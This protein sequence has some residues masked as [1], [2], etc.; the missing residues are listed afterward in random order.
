PCQ[1]CQWARL[2]WRWAPFAIRTRSSPSIGRERVGPTLK[3]RKAQRASSSRLAFLPHRQSDVAILRAVVV[4]CLTKPYQAQ[5]L[6]R[7]GLAFAFC[8]E[9]SHGRHLVFTQLRQVMPFP[10]RARVVSGVLATF[11]AASAS[12]QAAP[13]N[14]TPPR[15]RFDSTGVADTSMFAPLNLPPGNEF[16]SG[17]G[18]PGPRYWQQRADYD[19]KATLDTAAKA[20]RGELTLRYTNNSPDTLHFIWFQ[21]EQNAFKANSLNT[22]VFPAESRFGARNFEGGDNIDRF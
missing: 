14:R 7:S 21:V 17:S 8:R 3:E 16:R 4:Y 13:A 19:L 5:R 10:I 22:Y 15:A 11:I 1:G 2:G 6:L 18:A 9:L 20:L 12:A